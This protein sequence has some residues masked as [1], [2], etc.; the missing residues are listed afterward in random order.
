MIDRISNL[1]REQGFTQSRLPKFT[2]EEIERIKN[3]SDFFGI[4]SYTSNLV[5]KNGINNKAGHPIPSFY[6]I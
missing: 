1:S 5:T 2:N 3:T 4:N 6:M